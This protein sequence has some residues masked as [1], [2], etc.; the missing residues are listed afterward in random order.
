VHP[1]DGLLAGIAP[2]IEAHGALHD[3]GLGGKVLGRDICPEAGDAGV[4]A[5]GLVS[6]EV[7]RDRAAREEVLAGDA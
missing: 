7:Q 1:G 2:L 6:F 3:A 4:D 5:R